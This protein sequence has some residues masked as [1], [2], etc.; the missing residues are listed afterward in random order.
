MSDQKR[1]LG[2]GLAALL[3][4]TNDPAILA[5]APGLGD[6]RRLAPIELIRRN[7]D[8]PRRIFGEAEIDELAESIR[9]KG[10]LQPI[11]V[12]PVGGAPGEFQIV[13]GE[14][15][16][17]AAQRAGLRELP[18]VV[19]ELDDA[20]ALEIAIL[21]NVQRTDLNAIEE[22]QGYRN[23][24]DAFGRTQEDIAGTVGKSRS[25]VANTVRLL[26]LPKA[27]QDLVLSGQLSAGHARAVIGA[28]DPEAMA[29]RIV[30]LGLN[31]RETEALART[32]SAPRAMTLQSADTQA[33]EKA[34]SDALG[35]KV[36]VRDKAGKGSLRIHYRTLEQLEDVARKLGAGT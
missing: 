6:G 11:L 31:V 3:G 36:E 22:A 27:V 35:L 33:F 20:E 2:R 9:S 24:M 34:I 16:W 18:I 32:A 10:L 4:E 28:D 1:G 23:L 15:R 19:R 7:P 14:R 12:R 21:E 13:A 8:Q 30:D 26:A 25:H 29:R 5:A 17:R